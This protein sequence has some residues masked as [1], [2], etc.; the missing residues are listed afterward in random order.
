M[1]VFRDTLKVWLYGEEYED[2]ME[3]GDVYQTNT[4]CD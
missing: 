3:T 1:D 2:M 4:L